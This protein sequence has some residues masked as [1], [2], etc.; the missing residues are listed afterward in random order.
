MPTAKSKT[1][2]QYPAW[3]PTRAAS[4]AT[5]RKAIDVDAALH[6]QLKELAK[7]SGA[8]LREVTEAALRSALA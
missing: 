5:T 1:E 2:T 8:S 7:A 3:V 6:A 4:T